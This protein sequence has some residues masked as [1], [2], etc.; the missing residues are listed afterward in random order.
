MSYLNKLVLATRRTRLRMKYEE[1]GKTLKLWNILI[2]KEDID[3]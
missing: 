3:F 2:S 1:V